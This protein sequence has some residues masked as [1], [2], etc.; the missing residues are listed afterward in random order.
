MGK[1]LQKQIQMANG[2]RLFSIYTGYKGQVPLLIEEF[3]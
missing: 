1:G 3:L 2:E